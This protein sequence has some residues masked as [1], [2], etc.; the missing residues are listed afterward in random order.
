MTGD[1]MNGGTNANV[2]ITLFGKT[3]QTPKLHLKANT[4]SNFSRGMTDIF[5]VNTNCVGPLT[6]C[7]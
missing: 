4:K 5:T 1:R 2:H 3:G 7:R 6:K